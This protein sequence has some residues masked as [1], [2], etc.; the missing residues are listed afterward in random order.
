[1]E[2]FVTDGMISVD[3]VDESGGLE[4]DKVV[5]FPTESYEKD[6][7]VQELEEL[8][9]EK[10]LA[11]D[12]FFYKYLKNVLLYAES[13]FSA[14]FEWDSEIKEYGET[15]LYHGGE[16]MINLKRGEGFINTGKG[17]K[18][19]FDRTNFNLPF[20]TARSLRS[21]RISYL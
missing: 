12:H 21:Y 19:A 20:P 7:V 4:K 13:I 16:K 2:A 5:T 10:K 18:K 8:I 6:E 15:L 17:G 11:N 14:Q 9:D 3:V 1:M